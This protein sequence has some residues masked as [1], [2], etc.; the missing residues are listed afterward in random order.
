M[1]KRVEQDIHTRLKGMAHKQVTSDSSSL[2]AEKCTLKLQQDTLSQPLAQQRIRKLDNAKGWRPGR[3]GNSHAPWWKCKLVLAHYPVI[4][5]LAACPAESAQA[6][7]HGQK[8]KL[9]SGTLR[10]S[11]KL[12]FPKCPSTLEWINIFETS[13]SYDGARIF[14]LA[15]NLSFQ[16]SRWVYGVISGS[17]G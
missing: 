10:N 4:L 6:E 17:Y 5:V 16:Y 9:Y 13:D 1:G 14:K 2:V 12:L 8:K 15:E 11:K 3:N 7:E